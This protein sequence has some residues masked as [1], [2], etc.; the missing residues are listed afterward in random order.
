M[1]GENGDDVK[2]DLTNA[3]GSESWHIWRGQRNES[4]SWFHQRRVNAHLNER[5]VIFNK[6]TTGGRERV[7]TDEKWILRVGG[8]KRVIRCYVL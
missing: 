7:T 2:E 3:W 6:Q 5:S 1:D 4:W 8:L